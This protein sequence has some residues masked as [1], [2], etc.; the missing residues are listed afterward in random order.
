M[1]HKQRYEDGFSLTEV[2]VAI[3]LLTL[4]WLSAVSAII[5]ANA[6]GSLAKHKSQ[7]TYL[8]QKKIEDTRKLTISSIP[9]G[10]T[11]TTVTIDNR[12]TTATSDDLQGTQSLIIS[13][14][15]PYYL[16]ALVQISWRESFFGKSKT[17]VE[18]AGTFLAYDPQAN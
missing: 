15:D 12:G 16:K 14:P 1:R 18:Y 13:K 2:V 4:V 17:V 3:F 6:S 7:A 10:T 5:M 9:S 11:T 8:I